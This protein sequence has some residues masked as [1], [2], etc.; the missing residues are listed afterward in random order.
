MSL[1]KSEQATAHPGH[2]QRKKRNEM[3]KAKGN[4]I[5]LVIPRSS[6]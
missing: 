4:R 2:F 3:Q 5:I 1:H 6:K